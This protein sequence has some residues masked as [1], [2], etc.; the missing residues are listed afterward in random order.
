MKIVLASDHAGY[1][2]KNVLVEYLKAKAY[3]VEDAGPNSSDRCDYPDYAYKASKLVSDGICD[4]GILVCGSGIGMSIVANKVS[5]IRAALCADTT[6]AKLS[7]EHN[8]ANVLCLGARLLDE[9]TAKDIVDVWL[10][11]EF[12][13]DRHQ[14][15]IDKITNIEENKLC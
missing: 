14:K 3:E 4:V 9:K 11:T 13:G 5:K 10:A 15:R 12:E 1:E 6:Y 2:L 8:N 7:R